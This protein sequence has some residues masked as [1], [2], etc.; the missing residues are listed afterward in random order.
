MLA[1]ETIAFLQ[2][3][4][5]DVTLAGDNAIVVGMA[6]AALPQT[7][8]KRAIVLGVM[9]ATVMRILFAF[10]AAKLLHIIGLTLAGG[11]LLCWVAWKLYQQFRN[12]LGE[13]SITDSDGDQIKDGQIS[14]PHYTLKA[15]VMQIVVADVTMS[16]D[17]VLAVAGAAGRHESVM[18]AGLALSVMLMG[19]A[20]TIISRLL[21]RYRWIGYLG[22]LI[23]L[24]VALRMI[25]EGGVE[26][27]KVL[28]Q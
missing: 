19:A 18:I 8:R 20:A 9:A 13:N 1:D 3:V 26:V 10:F 17:N 15:A 11:I 22:L 28:M 23:I 21:H 12:G 27:Q 24:Y 6:A 4:L 5:I 16:L 2:V 7:E 14:K 25:F